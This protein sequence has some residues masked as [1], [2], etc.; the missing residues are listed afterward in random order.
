MPI[1]FQEFFGSFQYYSNCYDFVMTGR[2]TSSRPYGVSFCNN[3][4]IAAWVRVGSVPVL[5]TKKCGKYAGYRAEVRKWKYM[6]QCG[7]ER[8]I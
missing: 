2:D 3:P 7:I 8:D 4:S 6:E 1:Y 5:E